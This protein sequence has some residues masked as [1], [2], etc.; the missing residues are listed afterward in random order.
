MMHF[1]EWYHSSSGM[2][3]ICN[4]TWSHGQDQQDEGICICD[5]IKII[6]YYF[7]LAFQYWEYIHKTMNV[8]PHGMKRLCCITSP[9]LVFLQQLLPLS[10]FIAALFTAASSFHPP[11]HCLQIV[12]LSPPLP[13]IGH[14]CY[15]PPAFTGMFRMN[16]S[17]PSPCSYCLWAFYKP[18]SEPNVLHVPCCA[19]FLLVA[20]LAYSLT[21][22]MEAAC[23][24]KTSVNF[25]W[26]TWCNIPEHSTLH[27]WMVLSN[28]QDTTLLR[29][30]CRMP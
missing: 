13:P 15:F 3:M 8:L 2:E 22:K 4:I 7:L 12:T 17:Y 6:H 23:S 30:Q 29:I 20:C 14:S 1:G 25:C 16:S 28:S 24:S 5:F 27:M 19:C 9:S 18:I 26:A 10:V 21:L 11:P